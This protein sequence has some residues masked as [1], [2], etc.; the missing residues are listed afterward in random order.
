MDR[1]ALIGRAGPG[2]M[3]RIKL[4]KYRREGLYSV[5][6]SKHRKFY[7]KA[8]VQSCLFAHDVKHS[9]FLMDRFRVRRSSLQPP[10]TSKGFGV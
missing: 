6:A 3:Y 1:G 7:S 2:T 5:P 4:S 10:I 8:L 9:Y